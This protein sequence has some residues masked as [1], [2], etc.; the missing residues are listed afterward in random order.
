MSSPN[1]K[2]ITWPVGRLLWGAPSKGRNTDR[3][4]KPLTTKDGQPRTEFAFGVGIEKRGEVHWNQTPWGADMWNTARA[5]F[6]NM[7]DAS[8]QLAAGRK[9]SF[10]TVDGDSNQPN[11]NGTVPSA[12]K[13]NRGHWIITFKSSFAPT[14]YNADGSQ[15]IPAESIKTGNFVQVAGSVDGNGDVGKPGIY[16][17]HG[18]VALA[19]YHP[20]GEITSGP[21]A[22]SVGFGAGPA[23][24]A[25][26]RAPAGALPGSAPTPAAPPPAA[27]AP[28]PMAPPP[29][30][31]VAPAPSFIAPPAAPV[32]P[33]PPPPPV[34]GP[35][36]KGPAGTSQAQ[37]AAAGWSD[38]Q[39]RAQG[40]LA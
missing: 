15:A 20:D 37:Y 26:Q 22:S 32:A 40:L 31:A 33:T 35:V 2:Y 28:A 7:F 30:V 1:V 13:E 9:F 12:S 23:P 16:V 14:T 38:E 4:G 19:G 36:W 21:D 27:P 39:M 34:A 18:M 11:E 25:M 8:G 6:P 5:C 17:N 29:P 10:K 3:G 24:S